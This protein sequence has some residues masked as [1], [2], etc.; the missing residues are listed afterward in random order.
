MLPLLFASQG[1]TAPVG[2]YGGITMTQSGKNWQA[3]TW[4]GGKNVGSFTQAAD[5][6]ALQAALILLVGYRVSLIDPDPNN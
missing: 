3:T 2:G 1:A 6:D 5:K 4:F